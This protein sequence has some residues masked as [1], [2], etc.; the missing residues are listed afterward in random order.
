MATPKVTTPRGLVLVTGGSGYIAEYCIAQLLNEG[1]RARTTI[2]NLRAAEE[3][4]ATSRRMP[5]QSSSRQPISIQMLAGPM[6]SRGLTMCS[7]SR[8]PSRLWTRGLTTN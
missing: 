5:A 4:R 3:V 7:M 6:R 2:R 1:W 8:L